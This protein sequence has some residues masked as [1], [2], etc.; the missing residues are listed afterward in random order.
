M[1]R[2]FVTS[3]SLPSNSIRLFIYK[4]CADKFKVC[5]ARNIGCSRDTSRNFI[6]IA[7]KISQ[8]FFIRN[9]NETSVIT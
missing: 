3:Y 1:Y 7:E 4:D 9:E 2:S 5:L 6:F 8:I